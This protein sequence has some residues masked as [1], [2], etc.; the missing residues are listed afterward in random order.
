M[1][2][3]KEFDQADIRR[4]PLATA[5]NDSAA[6]AVGGGNG[7]G[8]GAPV[9]GGSAAAN[10][11]LGGSAV[12]NSAIGAGPYGACSNSI[13]VN[14]FTLSAAPKIKF[15]NVAGTGFTPWI[16]PAGFT[17]NVASPPSDGVSYLV[18]GIMVGAG[19]EYNIYK[20]INIGIDGRYHITDN[21]GDG[22][23]MD[24]LTAGGYLGFLF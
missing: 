20:T 1:F 10:G 9:C 23:K 22:I 6:G 8:P 4:S 24:G 18:P 7:V 17:F 12:T 2:E 5:A 21:S 13:H 3:Y 16:I 11:I 19:V 15:D 14:Q